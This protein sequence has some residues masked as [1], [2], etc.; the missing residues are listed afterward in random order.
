MKNTEHGIYTYGVEGMYQDY[1][2]RVGADESKMHNIQK[3]EMRRAFF[4]GVGSIFMELNKKEFS[5]AVMENMIK[6]CNDF[7]QRQIE[8]NKPYGQVL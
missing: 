7:W 1:L 2:I 5:G 8:E 6:E 3:T 4:A